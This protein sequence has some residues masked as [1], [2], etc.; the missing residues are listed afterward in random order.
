MNVHLTYFA[1]SGK[2]YKTTDWD[3]PD[4]MLHQHVVSKLRGLAVA[5]G[6]GAMPGLAGD[7]WDGYVLMRI[8]EVPHML[9][10]ETRVRDSEKDEVAI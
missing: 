5:G 3:V 7:G 9:R 6:R 10:L 2:F 1:P 4:G 8:G